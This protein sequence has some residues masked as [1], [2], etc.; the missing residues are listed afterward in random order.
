MNAPSP[1]AV[2]AAAVGFRYGDHV[3]LRDVDLSVTPGQVFGLLGPNGSGKST[4]LSLLST[5][6]PLR[7]GELTVFGR[8]V[9]GEA[10]AVRS[11]IGMTFQAPSLDPQLTVDENLRQQGALY[12]LG[13]GDLR[14][15][16]GELLDT[17]DLADRGGDRAASLSGGM[18]R[19]VEIAKSLLHR[20]RLLLL[21]EPTTGLDPVAR[22]SVWRMIFDERAAGGTT[23]LVTTHLLEEA[24]SCD[25]L[26]IFDRGSV[27]A[28]GVPAELRAEIGGDCLTLA[29]EDPARFAR[30]ITDSTDHPAEVVAGQVR[31]EAADG[32]RLLSDLMERFG[33]RVRSATLG[34]PTLED[35]FIARTGREYVVDDV[36]PEAGESTAPTQTP[37]TDSA[38]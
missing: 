38:A 36:A 31:I 32:H 2:D 27:V 16:I 8:S 20:P 25:R 14:R 28:D 19:K 22:S 18:K 37:P 7:E 4:F 34:K 10:D 9:R 24:E 5:I 29:V 26:A 30:E 23:V 3:A 15:R 33:D 1:L 12:G 21:D 35:V 17:F 13:G 11:L 6:A